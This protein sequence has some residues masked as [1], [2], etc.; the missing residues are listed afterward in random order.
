LNDPEITLSQPEIVALTKYQQATKQL[1][2]LHAR[3]FVRAYIS[4]DGDVVLERAHYEAVSRGEL[5]QPRK[6]A[7][8]TFLRKA[9]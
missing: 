5:Q 4:R 3:G 7:N 2:V 8:L 1:R 9:A 6:S